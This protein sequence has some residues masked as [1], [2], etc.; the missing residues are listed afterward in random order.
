MS[1]VGKSIAVGAV[2]LGVL[3]F[4][5][6]LAGAETRYGDVC[7][8]VGTP[9]FC[10]GAQF[11]SPWGVGVDNSSDVETAG[12]VYVANVGGPVLRFKADGEEAPFSGTN[13]SISGD[14]LS[15]FGE[16]WGVAVESATGDFYVLNHPG[17]GPNVVDKFTPA[18]EPIPGESFALPEGAFALGIAVDNSIEAGDPSKGDVYVSDIEHKIIYRFDQGGHEIGNIS[19]TSGYPYGLAVDSHGS[20]YVVNEGDNVEKYASNGTFETVLDEGHGPLA[21]TIDP[22]TG[23]T[24]WVRTTASAATTYSQHVGRGAAPA[25]R[26]RR[27]PRKRKLWSRRECV[28]PRPLCQ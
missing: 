18:G 25:L 13:A 15:G 28:Q 3:V 10:V 16:S 12:D 22:S 1:I 21:V 6:G 24:S 5:V 27:H 20:L 9:A 19:D 4:G 17:S 14:E 7:S 26:R 2:V 11:S 23:E 8:L